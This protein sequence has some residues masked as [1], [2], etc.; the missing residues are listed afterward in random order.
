MKKSSNGKK[1]VKLLL[2][3][4]IL[5]LLSP[6]QLTAA[7]GIITVQSDDTVCTSGMSEDHCY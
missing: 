7:G 3:R 5:K 6:R 1:R 4:E 2:D